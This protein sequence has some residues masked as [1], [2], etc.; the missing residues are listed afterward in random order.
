[1]YETIIKP[2]S[3]ETNSA[4]H[5]GNTVVP[6]WFEEGRNEFLHAAFTEHKFFYMLARIEQNFR[7]E[8]FYGTD[9]F[10]KTSVDRIGKSSVTLIQEVWQNNSLCADGKSVIVHIDWESKRPD[11]ISSEARKILNVHIDGLVKNSSA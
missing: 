10:V 11:R 6:I 8:I 1:M 4:G 5:I 2:R 7:N 9:V 3:S